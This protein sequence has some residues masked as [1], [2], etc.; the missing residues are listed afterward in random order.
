MSEKHIPKS[1]YYESHE[2]HNAH[3]HHENLSD[4][5]AEQAEQA[6]ANQIS[7]E[8]L[9][10]IRKLAKQEAL[11]SENIDTAEETD[12]KDSFIGVQQTLKTDAF[13]R[14]LSK[15]RN[16]LSKPDRALSKLIHNNT[17]DKISA[18]GS[19]TVAR[20]SGILS[21]SICAFLGSSIL[22]YLSKHYGFKY[23]YLVFFGLFIGGYLLGSIVE[24][25][26]WLTYSRKHKY[27]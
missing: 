14:T 18:V 11:K 12:N 27:K 5:L 15:V 13:I 16:R 25:L 22:L 9:E 21:G 7:S 8:N 26:I 4:N 24:L 20:P 1:E 10:I 19:Q 17:I 3:K 6:K 2:D 23:N